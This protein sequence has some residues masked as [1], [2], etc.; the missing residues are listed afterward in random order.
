[1]TIIFLNGAG[2]RPYYL[3]F[4]T[5]KNTSFTCAKQILEFINETSNPKGFKLLYR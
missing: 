3:E 2:F 1:M 5:T 4:D